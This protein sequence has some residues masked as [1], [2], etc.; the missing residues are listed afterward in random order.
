MKGKSFEKLYPFMKGKSFEKLYPFMKDTSLEAL[1]RV[2]Y[3][4]GF[5]LGMSGA[6]KWT[7]TERKSP[8]NKN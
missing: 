4:F 8:L 5:G 1:Q 7:N 3:G 2:I 6:F